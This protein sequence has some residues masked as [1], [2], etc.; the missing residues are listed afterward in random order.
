MT[1]ACDITTDLKP[2]KKY[3]RL[4]STNTPFAAKCRKLKHNRKRCGTTTQPPHPNEVKIMK[5][6]NEGTDRDENKAHIDQQQK[7]VAFGF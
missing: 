6:E 2:K 1:H 5:T 4:R 7:P 3:E